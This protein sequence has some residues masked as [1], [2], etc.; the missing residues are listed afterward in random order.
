MTGWRPPASIFIREKK[1]RKRMP[2]PNCRCRLCFR[3]RCLALG[4]TESGI[5]IVFAISH[6]KCLHAF[7]CG[8]EWFDY[9]FPKIR[10]DEALVAVVAPAFHES[11]SARIG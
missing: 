2:G 3:L 5:D 1:L 6:V 8:R 11:H 4:P 10:Q 9:L 7:R